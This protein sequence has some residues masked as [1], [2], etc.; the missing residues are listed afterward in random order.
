MKVE[1]TPYGRY[2]LSIGKLKPHSYRF[3][4][5]NVIY[6]ST[7]GG[8]SEKQNEADYRI[9]ETTPILKN[10]PNITGV[11]TNI[12]K[13]EVVEVIAK[14]IRQST[15]DDVITSNNES[16]GTNSY[17]S[18]DSPYY[19]VDLFRSNFV[20]SSMSK[21]YNSNNAIGSPIPQLPINVKLSSSLNQEQ[22]FGV[23]VSDAGINTIRSSEFP[24]GTS[25]TMKFEEPLLRIKE[26]NG[27][28]ETENFI[29]TAYKVFNHNGT[30]VYSRLKFPH[31]K[32]KIVND[33]LLDDKEGEFDFNN[34]L[35]SDAL[36]P[37]DRIDY[38]LDFIFDKQIP[39][40]TICATVGDLEIRNIFLDEKIECPDVA[41]D[42]P[43]DI[44]ASR[45]TADDLEEECD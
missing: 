43:F 45:V 12:K 33:I 4:D 23:P 8:F 38:Y 40:S 27:F 24:D 34:P 28:D 41:E 25:F 21:T 22:A 7:S 14:N 13:F 35:T 10:N 44:Y 20:T 18:N 26:I 31:Q 32:K 5:E 39:D 17:I 3:F 29:M 6:D 16:V 15:L 19:K 11:E 30:L 42:I 36:P 37:T 2:L 1:L 9:K